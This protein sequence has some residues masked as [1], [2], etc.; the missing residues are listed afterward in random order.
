MVVGL[1]AFIRGDQSCQMNSLF[2]TIP[3]D[4]SENYSFERWHFFRYQHI[5]FFWVSCIVWNGCKKQV[6]LWFIQKQV[7]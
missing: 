3:F 7:I 2:H 5:Q 1:V 4:L 6:C